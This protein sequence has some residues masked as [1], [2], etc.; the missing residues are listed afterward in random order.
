MHGDALVV[1]LDTASQRLPRRSIP[2]GDSVQH[3]A[4]RSREVAAGDQLVSKAREREDVAIHSAAERRPSLTVPQSDV[5]DIGIVN[6][7]AAA[8]RQRSTE[9]LQHVNAPAGPGCES[10]PALTV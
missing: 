1:T 10:D 2:P 6:G 8:G 7:E 4:V 3:G 5:A 9:R